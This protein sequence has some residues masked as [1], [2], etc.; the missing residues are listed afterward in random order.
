MQDESLKALERVRSALEMGEGHWWPNNHGADGIK[1]LVEADLRTLLA[2]LEEREKLLRECREVLSDMHRA[3]L[4]KPVGG[5]DGFG[6]R[7]LGHPNAATLNRA[8]AILTTLGKADHE[9]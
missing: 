4:G 6:T 8:N 7:V 2:Q 3:C 9:G 5:S 1:P